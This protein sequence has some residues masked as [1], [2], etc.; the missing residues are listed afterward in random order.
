MSARSGGISLRRNLS[1]PSI[2]IVP[3]LHRPVAFLIVPVFGFANAGV[4]LAWFTP[5]ALLSPIP[6]GIAVG[7]FLGKQ[8]GVFT[9][10]W[11]AI[12]LKLARLPDNTSWAQ[13]YGV[14]IVTG[15]G[16]T[17]SL[18]IGLLAFPAHPDAQDAVKI[19][20]LAGS[21]LSGVIGYILLSA[22]SRRA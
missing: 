14:S 5:A 6:L 20:V 15:I 13:L 10:S 21:L 2:P 11:L 12:K 7:L 4:S 8:L 18:F 3:A 19:G 17:M 22:V 16:F 1:P 9:A